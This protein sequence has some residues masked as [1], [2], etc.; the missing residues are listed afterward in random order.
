[1]D[2]VNLK[3]TGTGWEFVTEADLEDFVWANLKQLLGLTPLKRQYFVNGQYCDILALRENQQLVV[4]ELKNVEDR[5]I[6]QQLTRY[7]HALQEEK[8][9]ADEVDY[10]KP[11]ELIAITP[12][13]NRDNFTDR[14][15]NHLAIRFFEFSV[16]ADGISYFL[17][18]KDLDNHQFF[19]IKIPYQQQN[20]NEN[21]PQ[22]PRALINRLENC[23]S[24][25]KAGILSIRKKILSFD[26]RMQEIS[27]TVGVKYGNG[28][29]KNSK[30]C[31]EI[32][33]DSKGIPFLFLWLGLKNN[34]SE[35]IG[36]ARIWT[37]W[38]EKALLEGYVNSGIGSKLTLYKK[39]M[40]RRVEIMN[41]LSDRDKSLNYSNFHKH[42]SQFCKDRNRISRKFDNSEPLTYEETK[43][44]E[45]D[46]NK[47]IIMVGGSKL[48]VYNFG[49]Y[50]SLEQ[51]VNLALEKWLKRI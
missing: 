7:Y 8:P 21:V 47:F 20:S 45:I 30:F 28:N 48:R 49:N 31:A 35:R 43:L 24:E 34:T 19:K 6:V 12:N 17:D 40:G 42:T 37:D 36:R 38:Y 50:E 16:L 3:Q 13:F 11:I 18:L 9:F 51:L 32:Y 33:F 25:Q 15:Y 4:L 41:K 39:T 14:I 1:M 2:L 10:Q 29:S 46:A 27:S 22:P 44:L 5:Y 26:K 23:S